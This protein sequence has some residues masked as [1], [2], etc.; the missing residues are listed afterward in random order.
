MKPKKEIPFVMT[1][2]DI[3]NSVVGESGCGGHGY[4]SSDGVFIV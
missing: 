3:D 4:E 2:C 1:E